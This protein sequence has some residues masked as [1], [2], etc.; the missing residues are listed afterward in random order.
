MGNCCAKKRK[1]KSKSLI[2][3]ENFEE[4][5]GLLANEK[6]VVVE[7]RSIEELEIL[8]QGVDN[9]CRNLNRQLNLLNA[10]RNKN[11]P[12]FYITNEWR[13]QT[14]INIDVNE[15]TVEQNDYIWRGWKSIIIGYARMKLPLITIPKVIIDLIELYRKAKWTNFQ[16]GQKINVKDELY[17]FVAKILAHKNIFEPLPDEWILKMGIIE[18]NNLEKWKIM[19]G[20]YVKYSTYKNYSPSGHFI[21]IDKETICDCNDDVKFCNLSAH[22]IA[23]YGKFVVNT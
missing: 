3:E 17:W 15:K 13:N 11:K 19:E 16:F 21:F 23:E 6:V 8:L 9:S 2:L 4:S 10:K 1:R 7:E 18:Q 12:Y 20:I 5:V 22:R 14:N